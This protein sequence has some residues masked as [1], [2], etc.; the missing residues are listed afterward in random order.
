MQRVLRVLPYSVDREAVAA[1]TEAIR[2]NPNFSEAVARYAIAGL[3]PIDGDARLAKT[4]CQVSR[5]TLALSVLHLES[6]AGPDGEGASAAR[7]RA[8]LMKGDFAGAGWVKNAIRIFQHSGYL[9]TGFSHRDRRIKR[10]IPSVKMLSIAQHALTPMLQALECVAPLPRLAAQLASVP[11][12]I[13][14]VAS[15]TIVPYL[16]DGFTPLEAFPEI[17]AL[18]LHDFGF[19]VLCQLICTMRRTVTGTIVAEASSVELS[20]RF[21][22]SRAQVRNV[23]GI[24]RN[25][26]WIEAS[27]RGGH[28]ITINASFVS[29]SARWAAHDLA[30]W[31]RVVRAAMRDL[32]L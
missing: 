6:T 19:L 20:R 22:V 13:G 9:D 17:R 32:E 28:T 5:Y 3:A 16:T 15:H 26:G 25:S 31:S 7:L 11:G 24:A 10:I 23:L 18:I 8:M 14:A 21:G 4:L 2:Q 12:F 1:E 29:L 30:C 27:E